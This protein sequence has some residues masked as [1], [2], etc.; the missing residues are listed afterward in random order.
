MIYENVII[1]FVVSVSVQYIIFKNVNF[2]ILNGIIFCSFIGLLETINSQIKF[3][4]N[5]DNVP[6]IQQ[7]KIVHT[8]DTPIDKS[9]DTDRTLPTIEPP[10][11]TISS[12]I[13]NDGLSNETPINPSPMKL[14]RKNI[15]GISKVPKT[16]KDLENDIKNKYSDNL[17]KINKTDE[18][19][20][21]NFT[22]V[23]P[24]YWFETDLQKE[25]TCSMGC[26]LRASYIN[27]TSSYL[28]IDKSN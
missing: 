14:E 4:E 1:A 3:I 7:T 20:M 24:K 5:L 27:D 15:Q 21:N 25:A 8:I 22:I 19:I 26:D 13:N 16:K 28:R 23:N 9:A 6:E 12:E 18:D 17:S 2:S 10:K 11:T